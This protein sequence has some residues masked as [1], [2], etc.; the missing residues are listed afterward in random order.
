MKHFGLLS[1][2]FGLEV[3]S[4][5][6]GCYLSQVNYITNLLSCTPL[7]DIKIVSTTIQTNATFT[8]SDRELLSN[9][10]LYHQLVSG[11]VYLTVTCPD[12]DYTVRIMSWFMLASHITHFV[13]V[14]HILCYIKGT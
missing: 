8:P 9:P 14:L 11:L 6:T 10:S 5:V 1:Y 3:N 4:D 13:T 2:F 12:I 7:T